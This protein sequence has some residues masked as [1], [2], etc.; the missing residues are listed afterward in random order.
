ME[1]KALLNM[2]YRQKKLKKFRI[3]LFKNYPIVMIMKSRDK[4]IKYLFLTTGIIII[5]LT[6][7]KKCGR[8]KIITCMEKVWTYLII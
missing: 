6:N 1:I 5:Y 7:K 4:N 8:V 2:I 3:M